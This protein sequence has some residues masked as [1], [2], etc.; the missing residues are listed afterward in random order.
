MSAANPQPNRLARGGLIDRAQPLNF[1]FDGAAYQGHAGDTLA[2]ALLANGVRLIGRSFKYHRPR[3]IVTAGSEEPTALVELRSG[4]RLPFASGARPR[5]GC[6]SAH[7]GSSRAT[8]RNLSDA[9]TATPAAVPAPI[10]CPTSAGRS[11]PNCS[12]AASTSPT[13]RSRNPCSTPPDRPCP[14]ASSMIK[15]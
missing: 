1:S 12:I 7:P 4:A 11:N 5:V 3:G 15:S 14:A 13:A 6:P 10:E 8:P 2:A 9:S